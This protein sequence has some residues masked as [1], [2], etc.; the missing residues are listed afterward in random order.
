MVAVI[1]LAGMLVGAGMLLAPGANAEDARQVS[2]AVLRWGVTNEANNAAHAPSTY[3]Y[4]SAGVVPDPGRGGIKLPRTSWSA[5]AGAA[6]IQKFTGGSWKPATWEGLTTDSA[7]TPLGAPTAGRFSNHQVVLGAGAGTVDATAGTATVAWDAD[8][9]VVSY[10]GMSFFTVSDPTL[11]V[12]PEASRVTA[13]LSG[14]ASS[15]DNPDAWAP[16]APARVVLADLP[17][18]DLTST[19]LTVTP[20]FSGV[21]VSGV[22]QVA[23]A[24]AGS[25][26]QSFIDFQHILGTAAFWYTSG[27]STDQ[28]KVPLP[29]SFALDG[30]AA[31]AGP[32]AVPPPTAPTKTPAAPTV[33]NSAPAPPKATKPSPVRPPAAPSYETSSEGEPAGPTSLEAHG[34]TSSDG[35][36]AGAG[37]AQSQRVGWGAV[38]AP[39]SYV[40]SPVLL[41]AAEPAAIADPA[42]ASNA[43]WWWLGGVLLL[44]ATALSLVTTPRPAPPPRQISSR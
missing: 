28:F 14:Y 11:E 44:A 10:S 17:A 34:P 33:T 15:I 4:L 7:G 21:R 42:A 29:M 25:F 31:A 39:P 40:A 23:G 35:L 8:F 1:G 20:A 27:G 41:T 38:A 16:V 19:N 5:Q 2:G 36:L 37:A 30:E 24:G 12:T 9:T 43:R 13:T 32:T 3:N 22:Q 6:Q 18:V 26:P